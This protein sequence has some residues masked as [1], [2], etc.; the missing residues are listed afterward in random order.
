MTLDAFAHQDL[1]FDKLV[2]VLRRP[3]DASRAPLFQVLFVL[4][5]TST[6]VAQ[7]PNMEVTLALLHTDTSKFDLT[8]SLREKGDGLEV[9]LE[10]S[11]DL[12]NA[13]TISK[14]IGHYRSLLEGIVADPEKRILDLPLLTENKRP[15]RRIESKQTQPG[16]PRNKSVPQEKE[17]SAP[18][19]AASVLSWLKNPWKS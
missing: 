18:K 11:T 16:G 13:A 17:E 5:N 8:L 15:E 4:Q 10:Y 14:M 12:F 7:L 6:E 3:R 2:E 1:P 19:A 9:E